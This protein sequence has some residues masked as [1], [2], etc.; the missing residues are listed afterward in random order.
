ML[1]ACRYIPR[2]ETDR[3]QGNANVKNTGPNRVLEQSGFRFEGTIR[4]GKMVSGYCDYNIR[5][6]IREDVDG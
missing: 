2:M 1:K 6:M 5:G 4:H 3:L